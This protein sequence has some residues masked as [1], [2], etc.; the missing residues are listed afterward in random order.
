MFSKINRSTFD[1]TV[2]RESKN[3]GAS[4]LEKMC[5]GAY[6]GNLLFHI[7]K[8]ACKKKIFTMEFEK[9]FSGVQKITWPEVSIFLDDKSD[10]TNTFVKLLK[11]SSPLDI[12]FLY[13]IMNCILNRTAATV[14]SI[15]AANILKCKKGK[16]ES[17]K[18]CIVCNGSTF[19]KT[20]GLASKIK[21]ELDDI[22]DGELKRYYNLIKIDDDISRGTALAAS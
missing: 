7:L 5:S 8:N 14:A 6:L 13:F 16:S 9:E 1:I 19:W 12:E 21:A 17:D 4:I 22:L 2:D 20:P 3:P 15:L 10:S 18:I 11:A